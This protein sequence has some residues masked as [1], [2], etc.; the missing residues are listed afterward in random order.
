MQ[1]DSLYL[2]PGSTPLATA[3]NPTPLSIPYVL[4]DYVK[5]LADAADKAA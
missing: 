5:A 2:L 1:R 3:A 4:E